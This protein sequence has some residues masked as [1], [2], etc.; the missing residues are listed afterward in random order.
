MI[1]I[2]I[3]LIKHKIAANNLK[4]E[5]HHP[6]TKLLHWSMAVIIIYASVAGYSMHL[7]NT[8]SSLYLFLSALNMSLATVSTPLLI[9]RYLWVFFRTEP[10]MPSSIPTRQLSIAKAVHSFLYFL[11]FVVFL[12]GYLMLTHSYSLFWMVEVNNLIN[13]T[14]V[15]QLFFKIHRIACMV[16]SVTVTM[17]ILAVI[18]HQL[19]AK[20]NV[21]KLM[22]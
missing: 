5:T 21:L 17:H 4:N 9:I 20:N 16:L 18:K 14:E 22:V 11:M 2:F 10:D 8:N 13:D 3:V 1:K 15:N 7:L 6:F 12:S 19:I